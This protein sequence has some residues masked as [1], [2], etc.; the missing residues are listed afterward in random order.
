M[1][2]TNTVDVFWSF[3]WAIAAGLILAGVA[4]DTTIIQQMAFGVLAYLC[5]SDVLANKR[6]VRNL[7]EDMKATNA[8]LDSLEKK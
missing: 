7:I 8:R 4:P 3:F 5:I 6:A 1:N 2:E